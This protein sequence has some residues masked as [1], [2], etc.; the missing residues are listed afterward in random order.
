LH[1]HEITPTDAL[2][3]MRFTPPTRC[4]IVPLNKNRQQD[5]SQLFFANQII[6]ATSG[7]G[8][9]GEGRQW[10]RELGR[11]MSKLSIRVHGLNMEEINNFVGPEVGRGVADVASTASAP[12]AQRQP[13]HRDRASHFLHG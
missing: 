10:G 7:G 13:P 3:R 6:R 11:F 9:R 2:Q 1:V 4:S 5:L 12:V 8:G